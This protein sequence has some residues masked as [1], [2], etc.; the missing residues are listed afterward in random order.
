MMI[1]VFYLTFQEW[2]L[3]SCLH[4]KTSESTIISK[5][6]FFFSVVHIIAIL[7]IVS[8]YAIKPNNNDKRYELLG[9]I[10]AGLKNDNKFAAV[11]ILSKL[12]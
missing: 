10:F 8:F 5:I 3:I 6:L 4:L 1:L 2:I 7:S 9:P 12:I 11:I